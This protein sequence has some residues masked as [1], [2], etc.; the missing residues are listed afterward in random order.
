MGCSACLRSAHAREMAVLDLAVQEGRRQCLTQGREASGAGFA[1][2]SET[3]TDMEAMPDET[4]SCE[5]IYRSHRAAALTEQPAMRS[6]AL[7]NCVAEARMAGTDTAV[8]QAA[9]A[10]TH[11]G[12]QPCDRS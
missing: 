9:E 10:D 1:H 7:S 8:A 11:I 12:V 4:D 2:L 5:H 6:L 3:G